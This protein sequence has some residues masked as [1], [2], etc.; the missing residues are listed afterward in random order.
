MLITLYQYT[1][2]PLLRLFGVQCRF[3]PSCSAYA[4]M[5]FEMHS[6]VKAFY[7]VMKRV[8][9]CNP[10]FQEG[11]CHPVLKHNNKG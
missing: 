3:Y 5:A 7:L 6:P 11:D 8:L 4:R 9:S 1:L 2:S 10:Y